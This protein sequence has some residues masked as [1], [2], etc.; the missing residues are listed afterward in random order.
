MSAFDPKRTFVAR[1]RVGDAFGTH[2]RRYVYQ[3]RRWR[4]SFEQQ[5]YISFISTASGVS[6]KS[7][8][9]TQFKN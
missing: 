4:Y 6:I 2:R 5:F 1:L 3:R 7:M 8:L 9:L